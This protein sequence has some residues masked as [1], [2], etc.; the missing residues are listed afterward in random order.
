M[1]ESAIQDRGRFLTELRFLQPLKA[2]AAND[3]FPAHIQLPLF[4]RLSIAEL[5]KRES[6]LILFH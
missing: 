1:A 5:V 4:P 6:I 2:T 3:N